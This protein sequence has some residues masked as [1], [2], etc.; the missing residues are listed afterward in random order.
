MEMEL[1]LTEQEAIAAAV[2]TSERQIDLDF[3]GFMFA[4]DE[5][6]KRALAARSVFYYDGEYSPH[7]G[8]YE[9]KQ[10]EMATY[11]L[12]AVR[13]GTAEYGEFRR[14]EHDRAA[15]MARKMTGLM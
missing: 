9:V 11:G 15:E 12:A 13:I 7:R 8:K 10:G 6:K 4:D 14:C 5:D 2:K 3:A 1:Y